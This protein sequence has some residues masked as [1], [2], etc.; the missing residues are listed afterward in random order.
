MK[1]WIAGI[2]AFMI[3]SMM[4]SI[5]VWFTLQTAYERGYRDGWRY[6]HQAIWDRGFEAG[7]E[8]GYTDGRQSVFDEMNN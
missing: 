7:K 6:N 1:K 3:I 5:G 4:I 2:V 8:Q